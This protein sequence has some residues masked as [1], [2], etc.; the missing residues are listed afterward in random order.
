MAYRA[1]R[2]ESRVTVGNAFTADFEK[3]QV[4]RGGKGRG[5]VPD[6]VADYLVEQGLLVEVE[7]DAVD[8]P[9]FDSD[10]PE[11][12]GAGYAQHEADQLA[13]KIQQAMGEDD[14]DVT[15]D[16]TTDQGPAKD[17]PTKRK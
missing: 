4:V 8:N 12:A 17:T 9:W 16:V 3:G 5:T 14:T 6:D 11:L 2:T 7:D 15:V 13:D 1:T 10:D